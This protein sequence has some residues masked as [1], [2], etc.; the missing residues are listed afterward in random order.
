[1][2]PIRERLNEGPTIGSWFNLQCPLTAERFGAGGFDWAILDMQHR[3]VNWSNLVPLMQALQLGGTLSLVRVPRHD[4]ADIMGV[5]D[6]GAIGVVVPLVSTP[7]Q[8]AIVGSAVRYP[9]H[10]DRSWGPNRVVLGANT[11]AHDPYCIVMIETV[12]G[13]KNLDAIAATP[14]IDCLMLG[15]FDLAIDMKIEQTV[16]YSGKTPPEIVQATDD[17]IAA[18]QRHGKVASCGA[19]RD[20]EAIDLLRRGIRFLPVGAAHMFMMDGVA[21]QVTEAGRWK[22]QFSST[23]G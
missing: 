23:A 16:I 15:S 6:L 20:E 21:R 19:M 13:M 22:K 5:L 9:P 8:A 11:L 12:E 17:L 14:G 7:E 2:N 10:G 4:P 1:M 3:F 18:C